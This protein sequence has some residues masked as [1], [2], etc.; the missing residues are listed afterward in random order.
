MKTQVI[1]L[2]V[3]KIL[4][5][6]TLFYLTIF[7]L[8]L[9]NHANQLLVGTAVNL[10]LFMGAKKLTNKELIPLAILPSIGAIT[11]GVLFG[12]FTMFLI[13]FAPAI[14]LGNYLMMKV[15]NQT[16]NLPTLLRIISSTTVKTGLLFGVALSLVKL[17]LIPTIFLTAMGTIQFITATTGG[18]LASL[19][20][21]TKFFTES[22]EPAND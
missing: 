15:F 7:T 3:N 5:K 4:N 8:P 21:Q 12:S 10:M 13:Y 20:S 1:A 17:S 19:L 14:W 2:S 22:K 18:I 16:K 9:L 11:N 6:S